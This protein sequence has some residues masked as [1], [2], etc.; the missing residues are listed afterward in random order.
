[1]AANTQQVLRY[2][3]QGEAPAI[4]QATDGSSDFYLLNSNQTW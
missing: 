1:M 2:V 4:F 3:R